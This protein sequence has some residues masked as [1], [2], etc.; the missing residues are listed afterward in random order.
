[1][2]GDIRE[3]VKQER[4]LRVTVDSVRQFVLSESDNAELA[5]VRLELLE[6]AYKQF[7]IVRTEIELITDHLSD[8]TDELS[9]NVAL[10]QAREEENIRILIQFEDDYCELK[11]K[12]LR[13]LSSIRGSINETSASSAS[14]FP[15]ASSTLARVKLPEIKL[16]LFSGKTKEW[17]TF[18]DSFKSLIHSSNQLSNTDKF[19]YLRSAVTDEALQAI[20]SVDITAA[21][22]E[23]AWSTLERRY[24]NRKLLVKSY[25]DSLFSIDS[26]RHESY[27]VL[28]K[29]I[30][31]FERNLQMLQKVGEKPDQWSTLLVHM[32][33]SRLDQHTL[34][35]WETH[36]SSKEV[37]LFD[38]LM[39]FLRKHCSVLESISHR[40]PEEPDNCDEPITVGV[41]KPAVPSIVKCPFCSDIFHRAFY[42]TKFLKLSVDE[43]SE[44][45]K[46]AKLCF[47]CL[48]S[49]HLVR[50]CSKGFCHHCGMRHH[51]LLH[52]KSS[53]SQQPNRP[54][55]PKF[56]PQP[57]FSPTL[58]DSPESNQLRTTHPPNTQPS[59][60][61]P[62]TYSQPILTTDPKHPIVLP[63]PPPNHTKQVL[64]PT[65]VVSVQDSY[66]NTRIARALLDSC[67]QFCFMASRFS[68]QLRLRSVA[69]NLT[70]QGIGRS[71]AV[72]NTMVEASVGSNA[73]NISPISMK[74]FILPELTAPLP[75]T[76]VSYETRQLPR[77]IQLA[78]PQF[79][80]PGT[81]D[82]IIGA[83][84]FF[85]LLLDGKFKL[86]YDGP[87]LQN[88]VFGWIVAGTLPDK[89]TI[90]NGEI[91]LK[92]MAIS[93]P[94]GCF[95]LKK[96][97]TNSS[98]ILAQSSQRNPCWR[99]T[100]SVVMLSTESS[101]S[102]PVVP[103]EHLSDL[104]IQSSSTLLSSPV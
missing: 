21:N 89:S 44:A 9:D 27:E 83:E 46:R 66:G 11:S 5:S 64:L 20:A 25:L 28:N 74:F 94:D 96:F 62:V 32:V 67:S 22:Y 50:S 39:L 12:L 24:E 47:N 59:T 43:R 56:Q 84:H 18:R 49:R 4:N 72:S 13:L 97:N 42:C 45:V 81:I 65:A 7:K 30:S 61:Y 58:Q 57:Q 78:D 8:T 52:P 101:P 103:V 23:V 3:L 70:V 75:A 37:P 55:S 63:S 77:S 31:D 17:V 86:M 73:S 10:E 68:Q 87:Y 33:C 19:C 51:S 26:L 48:S 69:E 29:F 92:K 80:E 15:G 85:N 93:K 88:S 91:Y 40:K 41:R 71:Q 16:P 102:I 1:M 100:S 54:S 98:G 99:P 95:E 14:A 82:L 76:R 104:V 34:R 35:Q 60:S 36:H 79:W 2:P 38:D 90:E 6:Y 53:V